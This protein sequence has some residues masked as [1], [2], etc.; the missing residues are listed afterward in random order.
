MRRR[1]DVAQAVSSSTFGRAKNC[2]FLFMW[3]GPAQQETWD[4][5][6]DAPAEFRGEFQPIATNVPDIQISRALSA[7]GRRGPI[8]WRSCGR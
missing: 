7:A 4:L 1:E 5:K 6:P 3:G 8:G 2:I